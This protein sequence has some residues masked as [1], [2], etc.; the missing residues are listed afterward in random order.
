MTICNCSCNPMCG[1]ECHA[2]ALKRIIQYR[3][4]GIAALGHTSDYCANNSKM[5]RADLLC[6]GCRALAACDAALAALDGEAEAETG[7]GT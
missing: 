7:A 6:R 5:V 2:E 4:A 1:C 3:R